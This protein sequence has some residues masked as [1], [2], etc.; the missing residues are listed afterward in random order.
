MSKNDGGELAS[1]VA[2]PGEPYRDLR[3]NPT[4]GGDP[5][6]E[7]TFDFGDG[8]VCGF[9]AYIVSP[10]YGGVGWNGEAW[11][12]D[13]DPRS[14]AKPGAAGDGTPSLSKT[15]GEG[16]APPTSAAS[17]DEVL[18]VVAVGD[19]YLIQ[20]TATVESI[21]GDLVHFSTETELWLRLFQA[22]VQSQ[23][24]AIRAFNAK[25]AEGGTNRLS[26]LESQIA[27]IRASFGSA[28]ASFAAST[29]SRTSAANYAS[30]PR[31]SLAK[32]TGESK[33]GRKASDE[34]KHTFQR[35]AETSAKILEHGTARPD[36]RK[37]TVLRYGWSRR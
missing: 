2:S 17:L 37:A 13:H 27:E 18:P 35:S 16:G 25:P 28:T 19:K 10:G 23:Q 36:A 20:V 24:G 3:V 9:E 8:T 31:T 11:C 15:E 29:T 6:H 5:E 32:R 30:R 26:L 1:R 7:C 12:D 14:G 21:D 4:P 22:A 33:P 34:I